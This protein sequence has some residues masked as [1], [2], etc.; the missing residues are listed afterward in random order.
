MKNNFLIILILLFTFEMFSQI[1]TDAVSTFKMQIFMDK[2]SVTFES[3]ISIKNDSLYNAFSDN[4]ILKLDT[5]K[6]KGE[7]TLVESAL[8]PQF[9]FFQLIG[10]SY[11]KK[12]SELELKLF[13][14]FGDK[15]CTIAINQETGKSYRLMG[16]NTNDFLSFYSDYKEEFEKKQE[17]NLKIKKFLKDY[18]VEKLD[19]ECMYK[20]LKNIYID[21]VKYP[22][23]ARASDPIWIE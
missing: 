12:L 19:F 7:Y 21:R 22:C 13:W 9:K 5:L 20:G 3:D 2:K 15:I 16:F 14:V 10:H 17:K 18:K 23:L 11:K 6:I 8:S 1:E 4:I